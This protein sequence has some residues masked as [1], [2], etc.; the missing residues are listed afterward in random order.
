M[1]QRWTI[2][3]V[4]LRSSDDYVDGANRKWVAPY[5][6][7]RGGRSLKRRS[8][9]YS[10]IQPSTSRTA[11]ALSRFLVNKSLLP[12]DPSCVVLV[13]RSASHSTTCWTM[14]LK[15]DSAVAIDT[16]FSTFARCLSYF[17]LTLVVLALLCL[18]F[19]LSQ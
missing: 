3:G 5:R 8:M 1:L 11:S 6:S 7:R 2:L 4:V 15:L 13:L 16:Q 18:L 19:L 12:S 10:F 17:Y 9:T 14:S